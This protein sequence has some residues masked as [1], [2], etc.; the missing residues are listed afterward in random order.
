MIMRAI[1][2]SLFL[3]WLLGPAGAAAQTVYVTDKL[4]LGLYPEAGDTGT[5][6]K[7]LISGT[8]LELIERDRH[9]A[10]VRTLD[11][12][13]GWAK[14]AYLVTDKPARLQLAE[15]ASRNE[16]VTQELETAQQ[17]LAGARQRV[18]ALQQRAASA[19]ALAGESRQ[20]LEAL[21]RENE[22]FR[23]TLTRYRKTVPLAW[24]VGGAGLSLGLGFVG[25]IAWLDYRIRRR[26]GG[27]RLY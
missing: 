1:A 9:Y 17:A 4:R 27:Y 5:Q 12:V 22:Q 8:P 24:M 14:T 6:L 26:H 10:K 25:G 11:G 19:T 18:D 13:E 15:L 23:A 2:I 21:H 3:G 7:T 16:A 20:R